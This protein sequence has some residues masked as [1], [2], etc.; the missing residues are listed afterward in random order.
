MVWWRDRWKRSSFS[1][2]SS[3]CELPHV[4]HAASPM[5]KNVWL[6]PW[7]C[8]TLM[9]GCVIHTTC[10]PFFKSRFNFWIFFESSKFL[11]LDSILESI[12]LNNL[13]K[14]FDWTPKFQNESTHETTHEKFLEKFL[15][16]PALIHPALCSKDKIKKKTSKLGGFNRL[17]C[18]KSKFLNHEQHSNLYLQ[19]NYLICHM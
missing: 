15:I 6:V 11:K 7:N 1:S 10:P 8:W 2:F 19:R 12:L 3:L 13:I 9:I 18:C 16:V 5:V 14:N 4:D 17:I